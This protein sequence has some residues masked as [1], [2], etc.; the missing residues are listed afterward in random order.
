MAPLTAAPDNPDL[1]QSINFLTGLT[2]HFSPLEP[3]GTE[4]QLA[5]PPSILVNFGKVYYALTSPKF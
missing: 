4:M 5:V 1:V 2:S 3:G